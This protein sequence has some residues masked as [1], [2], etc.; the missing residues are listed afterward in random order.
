MTDKCDVYSYGVI[1]LELLT[2]KLPVDPSFD[3]GLDIV[4]WVRMKVHGYDDHL[5]FLDEEIQHWES[6]DQQ[7]ALVMVDLA[8]QCTEMAPDIRPSMRDVV[9]SL[10]K[11]QERFEMNVRSHSTPRPIN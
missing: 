8:L 11:F 9:N 5:D 2:R 3:E 10:L 7:E 4:S 1:L 6:E